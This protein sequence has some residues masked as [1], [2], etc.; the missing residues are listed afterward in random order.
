MITNEYKLLDDVIREILGTFETEATYQI[1][2]T[3]NEI[4]F[5]E[6]E[7]ENNNLILPR[8]KTAEFKKGEKSTYVIC[9]IGGLINSVV[10]KISVKKIQKGGLNNTFIYLGSAKPNSGGGGSGSYIAG[11]A[12]DIV[13]DYI[14]NVKYDNETI[15][16]NDKHELKCIGGSGT[17][18]Y[19]KLINKP[20]IN[21]IE[22]D[23]NRTSENLGL[24]DKLDSGEAIYIENNIVNVKYDNNTIKLNEN[25]ELYSIGGSGTTDYNNLTN[26]PTIN[27]IELK[28]NKT[29]EDLGLQEKLNDGEA[30]HI[31]KGHPR[32]IPEE[33]QEVSYLSANKNPYIITDIIPNENIGIKTSIY[34]DSLEQNAYHIF[35]VRENATSESRYSFFV[36][37]AM[38][39]FGWNEVNLITD[40]Y[41]PKAWNNVE[42]NYMNSKEGRINNT[43]VTFTG[44]LASFTKPLY[45]FASNLAGAVAYKSKCYMKELYITENTTIIR[46]YIPCYRKSDNKPGLYEIKTNQ[47]YTYNEGREDFTVGEDIPYTTINVKYDNN[48]IKLNANNELYSNG[49]LIIVAGSVVYEDDILVPSLNSNQIIEIYDAVTDGKVVYVKNSVNSTEK[50]IVSNVSNINNITK[51]YLII[52]DYMIGEYSSTAINSITIS[53]TFIKLLKKDSY[54]KE[55][56]TTNKYIIDA[57]NELASKSLIERTEI[58]KLYIHFIGVNSS[59]SKQIKLYYINNN[60]TQITAP[61]DLCNND[62]LGEWIIPSQHIKSKIISV[63]NEPSQTYI[64]LSYYQD[65][66]IKNVKI[67]KDNVMTDI[68]T[69]Y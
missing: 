64:E 53:I 17:T 23:Y 60:N 10:S 1:Q 14:I 67:P 38:I 4:E 36:S 13:D 8:F 39:G 29:S 15:S 43:S 49:S 56:K 16:V 34:T 12:I 5:K 3:S 41:L 26:K 2:N 66:A 35:S 19:R 28:G 31:I 30:T 24:Q 42:L 59:T 51:I 63:Y 44:Q 54:Y 52:N 47:F 68:V 65:G 25:N 46:H 61:E 21:N 27:D 9:K 22:L 6:E 69:E 33:Y 55:L 58:E 57:I 40:A 7:N 37:T 18:D 45:L 11:E 50:F 20:K 32:R 62:Y 48:T